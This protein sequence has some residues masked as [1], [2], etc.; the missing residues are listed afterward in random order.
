MSHPASVDSI[1]TSANQEDHVSMGTIGAVKAR[2]I[3]NN[4]A[5]VLGI[6]LMIAVQALDE[7]NIQSSDSLE[8]V[9]HLVRKYVPYLDKDR[10]MNDDIL[11]MHELMFSSELLETVGK[12]IDME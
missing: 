5:Y 1:S 10:N 12:F 4:V 11:Q 8:A 7:R 6:E 2:E 3:I 9:R